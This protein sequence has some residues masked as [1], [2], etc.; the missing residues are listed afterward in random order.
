MSSRV[1]ETFSGL[2]PESTIKSLEQQF[3]VPFDPSTNVGL[4][5][6]VPGLGPRSH[7]FQSLGHDPILGWIFGVSDILR[8]TF[9]A[10][11]NDGSFVVQQ[12]PGFDASL[13]GQ[14]LFVALLEAFVSVGGHLLSD[15]ATSA[16]LPAPLMPLASF[17][18]VGSFGKRGRTVAELARVM[19]ASGYD[20]RHFLAGSVPTVLIEVLVRGIFFARRS[21]EIE[22]RCSLACHSA[23]GVRSNALRGTC[24]G[25]GDQCRKGH[26]HQESTCSQLVA[27]ACVL[28]ISDSRNVRC[29]AGNAAS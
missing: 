11:G 10:M 17:L 29:F 19:Y 8:G 3:K 12:R 16:G 26:D 27:M 15:V 13:A 20:F 7:R 5:Q 24:H 2:L 1:R 25:Y 21:E 6:A 4:E 22:W 14:S 28:P 23:P 9:S 18:Q